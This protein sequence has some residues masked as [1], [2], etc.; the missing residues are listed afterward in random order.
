[1]GKIAGWLRSILPMCNLWN[2]L[3]NDPE[4][5]A[6]PRKPGPFESADSWDRHFGKRK[7]SWVRSPK[8]DPVTG[9]LCQFGPWTW[10]FFHA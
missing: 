3:W 9:P 5:G 10:D 2:D 4:K 1:M 6:K 8:G 7:A